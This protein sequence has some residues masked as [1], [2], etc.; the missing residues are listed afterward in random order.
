[1]TLPDLEVKC[2]SCWG[3]GVVSL[4]NHGDLMPCPQCGGVGWIPTEDGNRLLLFLKRH[5]AVHV[6]EAEE[7]DDS[8]FEEE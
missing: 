2:W 3:E 7:G 5:L 8:V 6:E 1:M 4:E